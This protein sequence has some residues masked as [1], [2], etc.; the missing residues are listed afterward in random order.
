V[1][2]SPCARSFVALSGI[3]TSMSPLLSTRTTTTPEI[4]F[5]SSFRISSLSRPFAWA[6]CTRTVCLIGWGASG[7]PTRRRSVPAIAAYVFCIVVVGP[8]LDIAIDPLRSNSILSSCASIDCIGVLWVLL[9][10]VTRAMV[11]LSSYEYLRLILT[12]IGSD[13]SL[14]RRD[15]VY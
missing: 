1:D 15:L 12:S 6:N 5:F 4:G 14:S 13:S 10:S 7:A 11:L 9:A 2:R 3:V 8:S